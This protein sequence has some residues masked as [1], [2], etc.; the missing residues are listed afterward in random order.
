VA[1]RYDE[2]SSW[3]EKALRDDPNNGPAARLAA[4]SLAL[5]GRLEQAQK[6][7]PRVFQID[8]A[9][10]MFNVKDRVPPFRPDDLARYMEGLRRA[11]LPE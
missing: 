11:G 8:P 2:A 5:E 10:R 9:L 7:L 4:V 3:A 1:G 6:A